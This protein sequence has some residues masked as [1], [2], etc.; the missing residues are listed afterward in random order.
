METVESLKQLRRAI[1]GMTKPVGLVPTMGFLHKGHLSLVERARRECASVVVSIF[2]NPTQ[3]GPT[4][5]LESY[6]RDTPR[7]LAL[8]K[9]AGADLVW[10]PADDEMYSEGFQTWVTVDDVTQPLEGARR[11]GHFRGV[12][13]IVAKLFNGV[14]PDRAYFGQKDAQQAVVIGQMAR[15][16]NYPIEVIVCPIIREADGLAMSSRNTYLDPQ[17]RKAATVLHRSL[18]QVKAS[19]EGGT[20]NAEAL[21]QLVRQTIN[22]EPLADLQYVSIAH[23]LKLEELEEVDKDALI[24]MAVF[25]GKT[26]LIDNYLLRDGVWYTGQKSA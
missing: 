2:V 24:S 9:D 15:D 17:Q 19:Y 18:E 12:T 16:L 21:R 20:H 5:D 22:A 13:T 8:L 23:P 1:E 11:P 3:F 25:V 26:R 14:Q 6:P 4:E 10:L 7:D